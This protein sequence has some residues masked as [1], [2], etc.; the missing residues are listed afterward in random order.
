MHHGAGR[1][2]A[3]LSAAAVRLTVAR[4]RQALVEGADAG[5]LAA[6]RARERAALNAQAARPLH[7]QARGPDAA[8]AGAPGAPGPAAPGPAPKKQ[9]RRRARK[10]RPRQTATLDA[11]APQLSA[12]LLRP[13]PSTAGAKAGR[14]VHGQKEPPDAADGAPAS[15]GSAADGQGARA[16]PMRRA[17]K[18]RPA[19]ACCL[20]QAFVRTSL[21]LGLCR[22]SCSV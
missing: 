5:E 1:A 2:V 3:L 20:R 7:V 21:M 6:L 12:F 10:A 15:A 16:L 9:P 11:P 22:L 8:A 17:R 14:R 13:A 18:A 19:S 4:A